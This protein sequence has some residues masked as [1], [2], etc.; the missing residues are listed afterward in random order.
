VAVLNTS[1]SDA[2]RTGEITVRVEANVK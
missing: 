1:Y 2:L